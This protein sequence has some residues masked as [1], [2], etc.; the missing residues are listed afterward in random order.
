MI[1]SCAACFQPA[2]GQVEAT[3]KPPAIRGRVVDTQGKPVAD[4]IV[5]PC[6][7]ETGLPFA[8][9]NWTPFAKAVL[10]QNDRAFA[11]IQWA[12]T[13]ANGTFEFRFAPDRTYKL[14]AQYWT[15]EPE[16]LQPLEVNGPQVH[17][18]GAPTSVQ[19][20]AG[21]SDF[22]EIR[23][24]DATCILEVFCE[25]ANS[26]T[27]LV[28]S[29][30]PTNADPILG[31][32]GWNGAFLS[33]AVA[34]NRMPLGKTTIYG[35]QPGQVHLAIFSADNNPGFGAASAELRDGWLT[36]VE[37]P[38]VA[39]WSNGMHLPPPPIAEVMQRMRDA[40]LI[41]MPRWM[42]FLESEGIHLRRPENPLQALALGADI[43]DKHVQLPNNGGELRV[44]DGIAAVAYHAVAQTL[45]RQERTPNPYRLPQ[46]TMRRLEPDDSDEPGG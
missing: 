27:L 45:A 12:R 38:W 34:W 35:L 40:G 44:G 16:K 19:V 17:V 25:S 37:V 8:G 10:R 36:R 14:M 42:A 24:S 41:E 3:E 31:F 30:A 29:A 22:V 20:E 23:P 43:I 33:G 32:S 1:L 6:D 18:V 39:S 46:T 9:A 4:A 5:L 26:D 28:V 13:D 21:K 2:F 11:Q 7:A 15:P